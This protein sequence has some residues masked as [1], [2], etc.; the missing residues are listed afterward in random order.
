MTFHNATTIH[1]HALQGHQDHIEAF[2]QHSTIDVLDADQRSALHWAC[3]GGHLSLVHF[4]VHKNANL[5]LQDESGLT[6]LMIAASVG[7]LSIVEFLVERGADLT[8]RSMDGK[9]ALWFA[10][11]H[12]QVVRYL[13]QKV[14][15]VQDTKGQTPLFRACAKGNVAVVEC[16]LPL[17]NVNHL[18]QQNETALHVAME[19]EFAEIAVLLIVNGAR[20]DLVSKEGKTPLDMTTNPKVVDY[21]RQHL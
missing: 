5:N 11:P 19:Q 18:D 10:I 9:N 12:P 17:S 20:V 1:Q 6:P 16:L 21:V 13:V 8:L 7:S 4:L 2:F 15:L 3:S 14:P